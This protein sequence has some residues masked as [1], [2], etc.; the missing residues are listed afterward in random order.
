MLTNASTASGSPIQNS[1]AI[2][3]NLDPRFMQQ[4]S[5]DEYKYGS[6]PQP[7][8]GNYDADLFKKQKDFRDVPNTNNFTTLQAFKTNMRKSEFR[9]AD[10]IK[11]RELGSGKFGKV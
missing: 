5:A 2:R 3:L 11:G 8:E 6:R 9:M 10:F 1:S 4:R 7:T